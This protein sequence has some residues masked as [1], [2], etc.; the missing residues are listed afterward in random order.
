MGLS[1]VVTV[2]LSALRYKLLALELGSE[3]IG[4]LGLFATVLALGVTLFGV[5]VGSSGVRQVAASQGDEGEFGAATRAALL[6]GSWL[7]G[8]IAVAVGLL[9]L[10]VLRGTLFLDV[11]APLT[12]CL[13]IAVA[14]SVVSAGQVG[15]LNGLGRLPEIAKANSFGALI[16]T[17]LTLGLLTI[18]PQ[19]ALGAAF[20]AAP[21]A[22]LGLTTGY[23][24]KLR[25]RRA[26]AWAELWGAFRPMLLFGLAF[27]VSILMSNLVQVLVRI[28]VKQELNLKNVG[29]FQAAWTIA[30]VYL[31][32][33]ITAMSAEYYPRISAIAHNAL[34]LNR[35][36]NVQMRLVL[37]IATPIILLLM[38]L[39]PV[40]M[41]ILYAPEFGRAAELLR[42]QLLGDIIKIASW[43]IGFLL[44]A[45]EAKKA[46]F[47]TELVWNVSFLALALTLLGPL[48]LKGLGLAYGI[49]YALY[50][51][52]VVWFSKR[53]TGY[54][55]ES[56][57]LVF[58][59][60]ALGLGVGVEIVSNN[61]VIADNLIWKMLFILLSVFLGVF[62]L[63][64][65]KFRKHI[66][67]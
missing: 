1:S 18:A 28:L 50:F 63:G 35:Q 26:F 48:G 4:L 15:L 42:W 32:F 59:A 37:L 41:A 30:S 13:I 55:M 8:L 21:L 60:L 61:D 53:L 25:V 52:S 24:W 56:R 38:F 16:G 65:H 6:R 46:F 20:T 47:L 64:W 2:G 34:E 29:Y 40:I 67:V 66:V 12:V 45:R 43:P 9:L 51:A 11:P 10:P 22:V 54:M 39:A 44:L 23:T 58:V 49:S 14:A 3:G 7:L 5:G 31:G 19:W 62:V 57:I 27:S 33:V 17:A 36:V